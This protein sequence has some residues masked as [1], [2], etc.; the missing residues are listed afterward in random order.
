MMTQQDIELVTRPVQVGCACHAQGHVP[1]HERPRTEGAIGH[2]GAGM[3]DRTS[4][5][6]HCQ[7]QSDGTG[8]QCLFD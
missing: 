7:Q 2:P 1:D 8:Q 6:H 3:D 5:E 4:V